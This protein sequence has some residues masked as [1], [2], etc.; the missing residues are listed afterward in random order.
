MGP[1][2][3][4]AVLQSGIGNGFSQ[5]GHLLL[6]VELGSLLGQVDCL[7]VY[8]HLLNPPFVSYKLQGNL[9]QSGNRGPESPGAFVT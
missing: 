7:L 4:V 6:Y 5:R 3:L 1:T 8:T 2:E 9:F